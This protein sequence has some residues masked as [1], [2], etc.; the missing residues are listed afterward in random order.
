MLEASAVQ[1]ISKLASDGVG[2]V[3]ETQDGRQRV[4][5][6][7]EWQERVVDPIDKP[8]TH[9]KQAVA[10]DDADSFAAYV[11]AFKTDR[12]RLFV[13]VASHAMTALL[14][15][16]AAAD[17]AEPGKP[18]YLA[19]KASYVMPFAEEWRRWNAIDGQNLPQMKFAEFLEENL[20]DIVEPDGASVL[21]V[22]LQLQAK[23]KVQ[24]E[25][26]VRLQD[27]NT[28]ITFKE[29]TE[30]AT[31]GNLKIP[32][33]FAIG[34]PVFFG[35]ARYR[36]KAFLRYRIEEGRLNFR[37]DLHRKQF[38]LQDAVQSA[39]AAVGEQTGIAPLY[40]TVS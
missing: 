32:T 19:H 5:S 6:P 24:F 15:Y 37:V 28:Q 18:D 4:F 34:I 38:M 21:E 31:R 25:S 12:S 7:P 40:G 9:I 22:A 33:E 23:K 17:K 20:Q 36:M 3:V 30:A 14:D 2:R 16:H 35:G 27:G 1:E 13:S 29:E 26:G 8:L 39:A 10:L 11:N